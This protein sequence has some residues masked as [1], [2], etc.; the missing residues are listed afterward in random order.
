MNLSFTKRPVGNRGTPPQSFLEELV[1][2]G[3]QAPEELFA[4]NSVPDDI[5]SL[6]RPPLGP[7]TGPPHRRAAMLEAMRVHAGFESSWNWHE[8]VDTTN[9]TSM[10]HITGQETGI[11]QVSFDSEWISPSLRTYLNSQSIYNP[12]TFIAAMKQDHGLAMGYYVRLVRVNIQWA[13]PLKRGE[14]VP[15]LSRDAVAEFQNLLVN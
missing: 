15:Y 5:Y 2:W 10:S 3:K 6:I 1:G 4:P 14:I 7:W 8:G 13:G 12:R 9:A 11:F